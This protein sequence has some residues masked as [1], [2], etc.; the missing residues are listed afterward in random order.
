VETELIKLELFAPADLFTQEGIAK[1]YN[2]IEAQVKG[3]VFDVSTKKGREEIAST[4][5][6]VAKSKTAIDKIGKESVAGKKAEVK[7]VDM[8]RSILW[9]KLEALQKEVRQPLTDFENAEKLR[10]EEREDRIIS[11]DTLITSAVTVEDA[12]NALG[13]LQELYKFDWQEFKERASQASNAAYQALNEKIATLEKQE[14]DRLELEKLRKEKEERERLEREEAIAK[15]AKLEAEENAKAEREKA[16]KIAQV[17][18]E[19]EKL[20]KKKAEE[21]AERAK[22]AQAEAEARAARA[23]EDAE[24]AARAKL[25]A[26]EKAKT[27]AQQKR[28]ADAKHRENIE[29]QAVADLIKVLGTQSLALAVVNAIANNEIRN[30]SI[31]Y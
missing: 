3:L 13:T 21:E 29:S 25:D 28:V 22:A 30:L 11:I 5:H 31:K 8:N 23:K 2:H 19:T 24:K 16:A 18:L 6:K 1:V 7:A 27:E 17:K 9:D 20:A 26:E 4:A 14:Q 10:I 15:K 12:K